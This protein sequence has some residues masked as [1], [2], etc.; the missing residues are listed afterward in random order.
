MYV[1]IASNALE[2]NSS[3]VLPE[4]GYGGV[5]HTDADREDSGVFSSP[6]PNG[7][8]TPTVPEGSPFKM[9]LSRPHPSHT[10]TTALSTVN[11]LWS[12]MWR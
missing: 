5:P 3:D 9:I 7:R 12:Q 4:I 8:L 2:G 6:P 10:T 11:S 1:L